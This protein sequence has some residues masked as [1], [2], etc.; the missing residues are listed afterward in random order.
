MVKSSCC[1]CQLGGKWLPL[2]RVKPRPAPRCVRRVAPELDSVVQPKRPVLPE[3]DQQR[4]E[5]VTGPVGRPWNCSQRKF[6]RAKRNRL[7]EGMPAFQRRGLFASPCTDLGKA[8]S[9]GKIGIGIAVLD[10]VDQTAQ[11]HL[12]IQRLPVKQ[13]S[14][15]VAGIQFPPLLT[16]H[17]GVKNESLRSNAFI[18]TMRTLGTPP[19][20]T[21]ASDIAVG[22][23]GSLCVASSNQAANSRNGSSASVKSP[24][25]NQARVFDRA[26]FGHAAENPGGEFGAELSVGL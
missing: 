21:V 25:V 14:G 20:S 9:R 23:R 18:S 15:L 13:Q 4:H 2:L 22:S 3:F 17:I 1:V 11:S 16:V 24:V 5:T 19:A 26:R 6:R 8:W 7:L 12:P 10:T